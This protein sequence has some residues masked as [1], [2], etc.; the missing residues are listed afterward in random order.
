MTECLLKERIIL[1]SRYS[2]PKEKKALSTN[3][4]IVIESTWKLQ[5]DIFIDDSTLDM[6]EK[7][8]EIVKGMIYNLKYHLT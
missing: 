4:K 1:V 7:I 5:K 6:Y 3:S 8:A 2:A